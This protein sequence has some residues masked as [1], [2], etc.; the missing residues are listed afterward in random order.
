MTTK[1]VLAPLAIFA[2]AAAAL[3]AAEPMVCMMSALAPAERE[4]HHALTEKLLGAVLGKEELEEGFSFS[5]DAKVVTLPEVAEWIGY[6]SRCC[7]FLD[8]G[9][10][11]TRKGGAK[12]RL[13][14]GEGVKEFLA[15]ELTM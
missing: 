8:F 9:L 13:T 1:H 10:E 3:P 14:G 12:L 2:G 15:A 11:V 4:R 6:E 7:P 5:L